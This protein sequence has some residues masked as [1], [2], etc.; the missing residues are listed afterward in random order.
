MTDA[1]FYDALGKVLREE[2]DL[3]DQKIAGLDGGAILKSAASAILSS[4][5]AA[6]REY[7]DGVTLKRSKRLSGTLPKAVRDVVD[8]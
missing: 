3:T 8:G 7:A 5:L 4:D 2:R 1:A 6:L